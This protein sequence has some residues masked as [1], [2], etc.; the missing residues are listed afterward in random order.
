MKN[1]LVLIVL[2]TMSAAQAVQHE[3]IS[4]TDIDS[5]VDANTLVVFDIDNTLAESSQ[6]IGSVQWQEH[7]LEKAKAAG[8]SQEAALERSL[9]KFIAVS[10][11]NT[12]RPV[13]STTP[14]FVEVLQQRG[15]KVMALTARPSEILAR[16]KHLL[17]E[18]GIDLSVA[19]PLKARH[20][21]IK[22][23]E[24]IY[25]NGILAVGNN[26]KGEMLKWVIS[27]PGFSKFSRVVFVDDKLK[28]VTSIE[29]AFKDSNISLDSFRYGAADARV[30]SFDAALA[31]RQTHYFEVTGRI[32]TD[33][34]ARN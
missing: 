15:A 30:K 32:L 29:K 13:E 22:S 25:Q 9:R 11:V 7:E 33:A 3:I 34:D 2:F 14:R 20:S 10:Y 17:N 1:L 19:K 31:D 28:Y 27:R 26:D 4:M 23:G 21:V 18:I 5:Y 24:A 16:T 6:T 12:I 8:L